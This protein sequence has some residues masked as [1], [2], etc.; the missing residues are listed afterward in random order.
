M[1]FVKTSSI[2][3]SDLTGFEPLVE[4]LSKKEQSVYPL[5]ASEDE[6]DNFVNY[7]IQDTGA[8]SKEVSYGFQVIVRTYGEDYD[9]CCQISDKV[10]DAFRASDYYYKNLGGSPY[11][12]EKGWFYIEQKF[13]IKI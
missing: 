2:V 7:Y 13:Q 8:V 1:S 9:K 3:Y 4:L 12:N 11:A 5:I 10:S 6:A